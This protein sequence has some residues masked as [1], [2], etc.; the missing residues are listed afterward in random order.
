MKEFTKDYQA[1]IKV[2][3]GDIVLLGAYLDLESIEERIDD[4][5]VN[6]GLITQ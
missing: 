5:F 2:D 3:S 6:I 1:R 4:Y